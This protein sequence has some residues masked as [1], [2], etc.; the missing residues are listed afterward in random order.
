MKCSLETMI[1]MDPHAAWLLSLVL[2]LSLPYAQVSGWD[3]HTLGSMDVPV[4]TGI[5]HLRWSVEYSS[6]LLF[7]LV[8]LDLMQVFLPHLL[9]G[10]M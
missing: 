1:K 10:L 8:R 2:L 3:T 9:Y 6:T 4:L 5:C 7:H